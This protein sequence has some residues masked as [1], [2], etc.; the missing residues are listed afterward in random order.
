[1]KSAHCEFPGGG[2]CS[3]VVVITRYAKS[4]NSKWRLKNSRKIKT[5]GQITSW[6]KLVDESRPSDKKGLK[7]PIRIKT[8]TCFRILE[9]Q[10]KK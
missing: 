9:I 3:N 4:G 6:S 8:N 5:R 7:T 10:S 1:M 2:V